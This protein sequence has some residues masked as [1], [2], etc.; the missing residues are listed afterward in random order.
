MK[1]T[2]RTDAESVKHWELAEKISREVQSWPEW[3]RS[4]S[5][6][7]YSTGSNSTK[8]S[9]PYNKIQSKPSK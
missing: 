3:K 7:T 4:I 2:K 6:S 1:I 8:V 9:A 5:S